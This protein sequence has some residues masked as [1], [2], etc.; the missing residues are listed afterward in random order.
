MSELAGTCSM[1][2]AGK[3]K[4]TE[5]MDRQI[6]R[7]ILR[8]LGEMQQNLSTQTHRKDI[9][10]MDE[11][12]KAFREMKEVS[13]VFSPERKKHYHELLDKLTALMER[14]AR[15]HVAGRK[16]RASCEMLVEELYEEF[17]EEKE[18][19]REI[20]FLPY[21]AAMWDSM[22]SVWQAAVADKE[23]CTVYVIPIP[24][25]SKNSDG[26]P[27]EWHCDTAKFSKEIPTVDWQTIDLEKM[28]PDVIVF[29]DPYEKENLVSS[30]DH[31]FYSSN[32]KKCT[33]LLVYIPY[34]V[35]DENAL[36]NKNY[37]THVARLAR[38]PG[39]VNADVTV[40]QS[41]AAREAYIK[42][43][44]KPDGPQD[45]SY[46]E[47]RI[48]AMGSPKIDKIRSTKRDVVTLPEKWRRLIEGKKVVLYNISV[49]M[50]L[51]RTELFLGKVRDTLDVF[52][53]NKDVVLWW[54]PHPLL[55][56]TIS[57]MRPGLLGEY[58]EIVETFKKE[59]WGIYDESGDM[60]RS[61]AYSDALYGDA[62][63]IAILF[64][65]AG[66][67]VLAQNYAV[68]SC[69]TKAESSG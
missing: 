5:M 60:Y 3:E 12:I 24:Y 40:V 55:D 32:L 64:R 56:A 65:M 10:S 9:R 52:R 58:R 36:S 35:L 25:C 61:I 2:N 6:H 18:L 63:S 14:M 57:S 66:K 39:T 41:E 30:V 54:R 22:E 46:W 48:L 49:T 1:G 44:E 51:H 42:V 26:S 29:H 23:H 69:G 59:G 17:R 31:R 47:K 15:K 21:Q 68:R 50:V 20:V 7:K 37:L 8:I 45:R 4:V 53:G 43:L 19:K 62:S 34:F 11:Y 27:K 67:P 28:H 33:D 16:A 13:A 38:Q